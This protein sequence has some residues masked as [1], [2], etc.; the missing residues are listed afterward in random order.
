VFI[1]VLIAWE[2]KEKSASGCIED[3]TEGECLEYAQLHLDGGIW[4]GT[5]NNLNFPSGCYVNDSINK[6]VFFNKA[7]EGVENENAQRICSIHSDDIFFYFQ[8]GV[9]ISKW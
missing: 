1:S 6:R 7:S 9:T 8:N 5:Q 3:L 2:V 4:K